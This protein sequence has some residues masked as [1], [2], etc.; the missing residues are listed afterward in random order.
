MKEIVS[1]QGTVEI[2]GKAYP[3][4]IIFA[5]ELA[6]HGYDVIVRGKS[7]AGA[8]LLVN[9]VPWELKTLES[10]SVNS[11]RQNLRKGLKQGFGRVFIDGRKAGLS[12]NTAMKAI[13]D[14]Y[15]AGRMANAVEVKIFTKTGE[16]VW[17]P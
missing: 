4:E 7:S 10:V 15:N 11:V 6:A 16:Y 9:G 14:H 13:Q 17:I 8:D 12:H 5:N 2:L 3:K 1:R